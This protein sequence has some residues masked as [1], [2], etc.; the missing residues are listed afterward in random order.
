MLPRSKLLLFFVFSLVISKNKQER[1]YYNTIIRIHIEQSG[2]YNF[3]TVIVFDVG[4]NLGPSF[5]VCEGKAKD[6]E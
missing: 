5:Q 3:Y 2:E 1:H 4:L 6:K